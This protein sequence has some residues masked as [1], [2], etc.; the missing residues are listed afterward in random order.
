MSRRLISWDLKDATYKLINID[1]K[2][3]RYEVSFENDIVPK[4]LRRRSDERAEQKGMN[5]HFMTYPDEALVTHARVHS[6]G[7][8]TLVLNVFSSSGVI[9]SIETETTVE[10]SDEIQKAL[11]SESQIRKMIDKELNA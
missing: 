9:A 1:D 3:S 5:C 7:R 6:N 8:I 2:E 11:H 4:E 10:E